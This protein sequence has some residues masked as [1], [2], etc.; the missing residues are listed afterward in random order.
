MSDKY[1]SLGCMGLIIIFVLLCMAAMV[2]ISWSVA[3]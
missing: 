1:V 2:A 3:P